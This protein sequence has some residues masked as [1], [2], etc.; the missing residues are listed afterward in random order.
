MTQRLSDLIIAICVVLVLLWF[1]L[2]ARLWPFHSRLFPWSIGFTAL[3]LAMIQVII[4]Y[5]QVVFAYRK[6]VYDGAQS[7]A[8]LPGR[9]ILSRLVTIGAW[10]PL[11]LAGIWV[12]GFRLGSLILTVSFLKLAARE[13]LSKCLGLGLMNY[14]FF[15]I[16]FDFLLGVPL[17][18]GA[19]AQW[20]GTDAFD[21]AVVNYMVAWWQ[22]N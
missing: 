15:L 5:R 7:T 16:V 19:L 9:S 10:V 11:F 18:E 6:K 14:L 1:V 12:L 2:E 20:L 3:G 22:G 4:S 8:E 13:G 21:K 17:F